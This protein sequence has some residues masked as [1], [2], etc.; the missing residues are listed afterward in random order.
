MSNGTERC[1]LFP[2]THDHPD[3]PVYFQHLNET[4]Q[5]NAEHKK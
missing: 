3:H 2:H 5:E 4:L 1:S